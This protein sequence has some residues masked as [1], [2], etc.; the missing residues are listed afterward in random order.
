MRQLLNS[1]KFRLSVGKEQI[2]NFSGYMMIVAT[3]GINAT[4][5]P[6]HCMAQ[7]AL[8]HPTPGFAF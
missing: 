8:H 7:Q 2:K 3:S 4:R 1:K 6:I 5:M